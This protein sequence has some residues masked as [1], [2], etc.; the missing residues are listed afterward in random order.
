MQRM[1]SAITLLTAIAAG[2]SSGAAAQQV[3]RNDLRD[4]HDQNPERVA[5]I[6]PNR[7]EETPVSRSP[8]KQR[9]QASR[10]DALISDARGSGLAKPMPYATT[11]T[12]RIEQIP[13][14]FGAE[15]A[16][17]LI[18]MSAV[19]RWGEKVGKIVAVV[20]SPTDGFLAVVDA[21]EYFGV[22]ARP[23][24]FPIEP[25]RIDRN[26][27]LRVQAS[28]EELERLPVFATNSSVEAAQL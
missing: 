9:P 4:Q 2:Y 13:G 15:K 25:G 5:A 8:Q 16:A 22:G 11:M 14:P 23:L 26:G 28:R 20:R 10:N 17:R 18:G 3:S 27:N 6:Y 7:E 19:S 12:V 1:L 21:G 24:A